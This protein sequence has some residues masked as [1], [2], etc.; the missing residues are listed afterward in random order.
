MRLVLDG[1]PI[2]DFAYVVYLSLAILLSLIVLL[3]SCIFSYKLI[4]QPP[5]LSPYTKAPLRYASDL[6]FDSKERVLRFLFEMHQYDN[7]MFDLEKAAFCRETGR[8]FSHAVTWYGVIKV[9]WN[10]L[11]KRF[12]GRYV[13]WGSLSDSQKEL[14]SSFHHSLEGF[15]TEYSSPHPAPSSVDAFYAMTIPGPLYVDFDRKIL[16]GWKSV[17]LTDLEVL[18]VQKP[19]G[20]FEPKKN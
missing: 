12:P 19:K 14:I 5:S 20:I 7:S 10:F 9:D 3:A 17:P 2:T 4:N 15:Q 1:P 16:L 18:V 11:N 8:I 13:S 6:S